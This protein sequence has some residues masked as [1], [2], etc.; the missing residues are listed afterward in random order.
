MN[1]TLNY[2]TGN[3]KWLV[4]DFIVWGDTDTLQADMLV[5]EEG[6]A[7]DRVVFIHEFAGGNPQIV[8]FSDLTDHRGNQLP[9]TI[10]NAEIIL[11]P[12][13]ETAAFVHGDIGSDSFRIAK[14]SDRAS[15]ATVDLL[16]MEMN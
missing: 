12:R 4:R 7:S 3:R 10:N 6:S 5:T 8:N 11:V 13:S 16:I 15:Y 14:S 9:S 1:D 2:L